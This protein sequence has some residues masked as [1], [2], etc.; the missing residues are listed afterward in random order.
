MIELFVLVG[1][2]AL[3]LLVVAAVLFGLHQR[4]QGTVR[5]VLMPRHEGD[6]SASSRA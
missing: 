4:R 3:V 5:A 1:L 6:D 2:V